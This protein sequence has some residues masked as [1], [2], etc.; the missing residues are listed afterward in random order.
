LDVA[1]QMKACSKCEE[2]KALSEFALNKFSADGLRSHCKLCCREYWRNYRKNPPAS[3][4]LLTPEERLTKRP[5]WARKTKLKN[6]YGITEE[7][8]QAMLRAQNGV[9]E[10]CSKPETWKNQYGK[11]CKLSIDHDHKT[12]LVR[13]LVCSRCNRLLSFLE[14]NHRIPSALAYLEKY[15]IA[16]HS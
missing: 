9:C 1:V 15:K 12:G 5:H 3:R 4:Q 7:Q 6:V 13:G 14:H 8:Y 2:V 16:Q 11:V 10:I